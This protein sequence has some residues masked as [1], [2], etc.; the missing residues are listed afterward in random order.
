MV[1]SD[2]SNNV[3]NNVNNNKTLFSADDGVLI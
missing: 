3:N 1:F 2:P